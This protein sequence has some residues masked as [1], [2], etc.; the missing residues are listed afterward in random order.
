MFAERNR[1]LCSKPA[2]EKIIE[3]IKSKGLERVVVAACTPRM[4]LQTF[5]NV[6][7]RVGLNP[8]M[9]EFVNIREQC[10]W[11][12]GPKASEKATRKA[13]S[14]IRGG[15]ERSL[16]LEPLEPITMK[17]SREILVVG[18]GIAGI[19]AALE[20][21]NLGFKVHLVEKSPTLGGN[22]AKL[23]KVFPTLDCAQCI[24]T[25]K[26]AE[27]AR[28]PNIHI[29]TNAEV[30]E[31]SGHV[32]KFKVKVTVKPKFVKEGV[33]NGCDECVKV[34]PIEVPNEMDENLGPR[35]AIY[36]PFPQAVPMVYNID[37]NQCI[38]CYKCVEVCAPKAIDF[39]QKPVD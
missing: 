20:L 23:T 5:Q 17:C 21:G 12:H 8:Y 30:K 33:C 38:Q 4:H 29:L 36:I 3:A 24:L 18:G 15:Y 7:E 39:S 31:V 34:C 14:L 22:M 27:V 32:G 1:Y 6:M 2:Q 19:T 13:L 10:S 37:I 9:L 26:M 28:N 35:K 25:P 11:V 16:E